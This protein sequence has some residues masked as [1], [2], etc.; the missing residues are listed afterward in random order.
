[1][2]EIPLREAMH[3]ILPN[4]VVYRMKAHL[5]YGAWTYRLTD[6]LARIGVAYVDEFEG[7]GIH[8]WP[9]FREA[10]AA[11]RM[12]WIEKG[13]SAPKITNPLLEFAC[14]WCGGAVNRAHFI[15][16]TCGGFPPNDHTLSSIVT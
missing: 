10:H 7:E 8:F 16:Y 13:F 11:L 15:C 6:E 9:E 1:M 3:G 14:D 5:Q 12:M 4:D 2:D